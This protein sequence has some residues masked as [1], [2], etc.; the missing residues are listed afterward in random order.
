MYGETRSG[1]GGLWRTNGF[2]PRTRRCELFAAFCARSNHTSPGEVIRTLVDECVYNNVPDEEIAMHT[3]ILFCAL[4]QLVEGAAE[5]HRQVE[6]RHVAAMEALSRST[7]EVR[8][9]RSPSTRASSSQYTEVTV[10]PPGATSVERSATREPAE[11]G[12]DMLERVPTPNVALSAPPQP[13]NAGVRLHLSGR[14]LVSPSWTEV[15][16]K[17]PAPQTPSR[18][19]ASTS[20]PTITREQDVDFRHRI[21]L[22]AILQRVVTNV[23]RN[24]VLA[25]PFQRGGQHVA[26]SPASPRTTRPQKRQEHPSIGGP[27]QPTTSLNDLK[28]QRGQANWFNVALPATDIEGLVKSADEA[29]KRSQDVL[30]SPKVQRTLSSKACDEARSPTTVWGLRRSFIDAS[31]VSDITSVSDGDGAL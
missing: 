30:Q 6:D 7:H 23:V 15:D 19:T 11:G 5:V 10:P 24:H 27:A 3:Q 14:P 13:A 12:K 31:H 17:A 18:R 8:V 25:A 2:C 9:N 1:D 26:A 20:K 21:F 16:R 29:M 22:K 4:K 28:P